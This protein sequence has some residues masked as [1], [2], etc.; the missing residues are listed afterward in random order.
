VSRF[1]ADGDGVRVFGNSVKPVSLELV[2]TANYDD[3]Q[4]ITHNIIYDQIDADNMVQ[5]AIFTLTQYTNEL[6]HLK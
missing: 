3:L 2:H 5:Q 4:I 1:T 6:T